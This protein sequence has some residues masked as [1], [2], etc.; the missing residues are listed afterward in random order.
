MSINGVYPIY[1]NMSESRLGRE[2][3]ITTKNISPLLFLGIFP[4]IEN[5]R[6]FTSQDTFPLQLN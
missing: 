6:Q 3:H 1:N 4:L 5:Y 2:G